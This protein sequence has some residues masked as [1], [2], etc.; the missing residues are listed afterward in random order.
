M[1]EHITLH[2]GRVD[3]RTIQAREGRTMASREKVGLPEARWSKIAGS[4]RPRPAVKKAAPKGHEAF[5]KALESFGAMVKFWLVSESTT[6][7]GVIKTS[8]KFTISIMEDGSTQPVVVF[9]HDISRFQPMQSR[10]TE[11]N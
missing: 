2:T 9:K 8:D 7:T 10:P 11:V 4:D 3:E 5:L 1:N 6:I